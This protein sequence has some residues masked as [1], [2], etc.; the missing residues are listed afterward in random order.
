MI[1][2][3]LLVIPENIHPPNGGNFC[4]PSKFLSGQGMNVF[5]NDPL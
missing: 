2:G 3:A 1:T 4:R 5:W